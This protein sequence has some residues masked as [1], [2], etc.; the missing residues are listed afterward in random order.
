MVESVYS[1]QS[2][3]VMKIMLWVGYEDSSYSLLFYKTREDFPLREMHSQSCFRMVTQVAL[4]W[5]EDSRVR[6]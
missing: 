1:T 4:R 3:T 6:S 5:S 2:M